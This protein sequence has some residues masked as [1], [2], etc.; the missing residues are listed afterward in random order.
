MAA[1]GAIFSAAIGIQNL[2][3]SD[4]KEKSRA[5]LSRLEVVRTYIAE[6]GG[7]ESAIQAAKTKLSRWKSTQR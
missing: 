4:L 5:I 3:D 2:G 7:L 6:Q 1:G